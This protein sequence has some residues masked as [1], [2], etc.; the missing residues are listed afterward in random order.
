MFPAQLSANQ[1][2]EG[3]KIG[4][5]L[6]QDTERNRIALLSELADGR[7]K[8]GEVRAGRA[9][10]QVHQFVNSRCAP[11]TAHHIQNARGLFAIVSI[12]GSTNGVQAD[13]VAGSFISKA[14]TPT[15]RAFASPIGCPADA[16]GSRSCD[17]ENAGTALK[18]SVER[19]HLI[20]D[21]FRSLDTK[22]HEDRSDPLR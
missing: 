11:D 22:V 6:M 9:V 13:P 20:A 3:D 12:Q 1:K 4:P 19:N 2:H 21:N 17:L 10:A 15:T 14:R 18:S 5:R 16:I 8:R 7:G